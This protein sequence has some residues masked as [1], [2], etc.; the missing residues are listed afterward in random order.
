[1]P[2]HVE[3]APKIDKD[4]E[5]VVPKLIDKYISCVLTNAGQY[6]ELNAVVKRVRTHH[7]TTI[8]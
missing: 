5:K 8:Q 1:M 4:Y 6:P 7:N 3:N 2:I